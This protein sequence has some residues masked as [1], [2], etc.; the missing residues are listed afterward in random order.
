M[1]V[2]LTNKIIL[3]LKFDDNLKKTLF[4]I[5][6]ESKNGCWIEKNELGYVQRRE[7]VEIKIII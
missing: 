1:P 2:M 4:Q 6:H 5:G 7:W 3:F